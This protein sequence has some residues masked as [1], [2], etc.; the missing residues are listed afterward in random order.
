MAGFG[1]ME[2]AC[3]DS[4]DLLRVSLPRSLGEWKAA[5][6]EDRFYDAKT[7]FEYIDGAGE[8]YRAYGMKR[9][10]ARRYA[11]VQGAGI[12]LDIF[13]MG[14]PAEAYGVFTHDLD[15]DP[16]QVGQE[17]LHRAG[18]LR[19]WKGSYFVSILDEVQD[20]ASREAASDLA[21]IV[22]E[23]IRES[24]AKPDLVSR[25]PAPG[26]QT[27]TIRYLHDPVILN[28]HFYLSDENILRLEPG[29]EAA[30]AEYRRDGR[31]A[32][33][34]LVV[35]YPSAEKAG[36]ALRSVLRHYL[37]DA[38]DHAALLENGKWSAVGLRGRIVAFVPEADTA[39]LSRALVSETLASAVRE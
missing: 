2:T 36:D 9:C 23:M 35:S 13:D 18:W 17:G 26:L 20:P 21:R 22:S 39:D 32:A 27:G 34:L 30:L 4:L 11:G 31:G 37:P 10:L 16:V 1:S 7:I 5:E 8:V 6:G 25:L 12:V 28:T 33:M 14:S 15:G 3:G 38:V 19:F 24:G 29:A